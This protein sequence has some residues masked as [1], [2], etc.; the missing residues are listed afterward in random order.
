MNVTKAVRQA[1]IQFYEQLSDVQDLD[2]D[3]KHT[4]LSTNCSHMLE[5]LQ[6]VQYDS[7]Y[8]TTNNIRKIKKL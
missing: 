7:Q 6:S 3:D 1:S 4:L 8:N 2:P 5:M